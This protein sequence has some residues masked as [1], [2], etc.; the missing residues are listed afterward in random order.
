MSLSLDQQHT[1]RAEV[2]KHVDSI[3]CI[4][5]S[6]GKAMFEEPAQRLAERISHRMIEPLCD[7]AEVALRAFEALI[8]YGVATSDQTAVPIATAMATLKAATRPMRGVGCDP[9]AASATVFTGGKE[10]ATLLLEAMAAGC[11]E[12][13]GVPAGRQRTDDPAAPGIW[14][15]RRNKFV[16]SHNGHPLVLLD[17]SEHSLPSDILNWYA[18]HYAFERSKLTYT[19]VDT[20]CVPHDP[21]T[22]IP[23]DHPAPHQP[24]EYP[25]QP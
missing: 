12:S 21:N 16:V 23:L 3:G 14:A 6:V 10:E 19:F 22:G 8:D 11:S 2:R 18:K 5:P 24:T 9:C 25:S 1:L 7:A 15:A 20:L 13:Q 17:V 4:Y